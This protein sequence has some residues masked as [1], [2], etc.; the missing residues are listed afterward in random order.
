[1]TGVSMMSH[2]RCKLE[3]AIGIGIWGG[4]DMPYF[5]LTAEANGKVSARGREGERRD[6]RTER[7]MV[8]WDSARHIGQDGLAIFIDGEKEI[9][10][11]CEA[12]S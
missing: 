3:L 12:D 9:A 1:M 10:A 6:L 2:E 4:W 7:E 5:D 11:G 8:Y